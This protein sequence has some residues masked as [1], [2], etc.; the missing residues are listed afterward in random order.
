MDG[1]TFLGRLDINL[2]LSCPY[3]NNISVP[4]VVYC[5]IK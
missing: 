1:D 4:L 2:S 3:I 5:I